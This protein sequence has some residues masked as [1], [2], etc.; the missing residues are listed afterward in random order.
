MRTLDEWMDWNNEYI[1]AL[2]KYNGKNKFPK[3]KLQRLLNELSDVEVDISL[4]SWL[5][6]TVRRRYQEYEKNY[7]YCSEFI[8]YMMQRIGMMKK[9]ITPSSYKPWELLYDNL[10][11]NSGY[12]YLDPVLLKF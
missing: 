5:K 6:S 11:L 12:S 1:V 9:I 4:V 3:K 10:R 8:A 2:R 7:Y